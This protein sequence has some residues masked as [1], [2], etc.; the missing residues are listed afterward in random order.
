[1]PSTAN[2]SSWHKMQIIVI[3]MI[4]AI[5]IRW[6]C[7]F[8]SV[9]IFCCTHIEWSAAKLSLFFPFQFLYSI[10]LSKIS[11]FICISFVFRFIV[12]MYWRRFIFNNGTKLQIE[13]A[14]W[15]EKF[16]IFVGWLKSNN[17]FFIFS[18]RIRIIVISDF[19]VSAYY[20]L[21]TIYINTCNIANLMFLYCKIFQVIWMK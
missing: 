3:V 4:Q 1:M 19:G 21:R 5:N 2:K 16:A 8:F 10:N 20:V 9:F 7:N 13:I 6:T 14:K 15:C 17:I 12:M 11:W 18:G